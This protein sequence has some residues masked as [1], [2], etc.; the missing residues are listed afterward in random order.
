MKSFFIK[1]E[2]DDDAGDGWDDDDDDDDAGDG[3][4]DDDAGDGWDAPTF[5]VL[6]LIGAHQLQNTN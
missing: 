6:P 4:D 3:W 1:D 2:D 5:R